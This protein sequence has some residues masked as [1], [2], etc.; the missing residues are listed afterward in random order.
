MKAQLLKCFVH[1]MTDTNE[2]ESNPCV[3]N[4]TCTD[5]VN[6]FNCSCPPGFHGDRCEKGFFFFNLF[7]STKLN[8]RKK[9]I[10]IFFF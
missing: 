1:Y 10:D 3:N 8:G 2:C 9:D 6:G 5:L 7:S 4:G